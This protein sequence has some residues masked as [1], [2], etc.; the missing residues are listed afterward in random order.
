[1]RKKYILR[2][3]ETFGSKRPIIPV[4]LRYGK[5]EITHLVLID[6]GA[7]VNIINRELAD[8]LN[9]DLDTLSD[10]SYGGIVG[11]PVVGKEAMISMGFEDVLFDCPIIFGDLKQD[12][13][14]IVGQRG[15]FDFFKICFD[16][17][18]NA[19]ILKPNNKLKK[20]GK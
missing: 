3:I 2:Y 13:Y 19:I 8:V 11:S 17:C 14:S 6:S 12:K 16:Y 4:T 1:M 10:I 20:R 5:R 18:S 9:I 15:F 7:D